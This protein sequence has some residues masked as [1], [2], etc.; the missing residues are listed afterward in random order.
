L[1]DGE[2]NRRRTRVAVADLALLVRQFATVT[3]IPLKSSAACSASRANE[4]RVNFAR[5]DG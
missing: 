3:I 2:N 4:L 1:I 5:A